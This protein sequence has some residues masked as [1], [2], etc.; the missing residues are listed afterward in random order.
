MSTLSRA[1]LLAGVFLPTIGSLGARADAPRGIH[2]ARYVCD[3]DGRCFETGDLDQRDDDDAPRR[4]DDRRLA[5]PDDDRDPRDF[6][7][8][9]PPPRDYDRRPAP[10]RDQDRRREPR[11][12]DDA[13]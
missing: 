6:D 13:D 8:R 5:P 7:R 4:H 9:P 2:P 12:D 11:D 3:A 10:P 1:L